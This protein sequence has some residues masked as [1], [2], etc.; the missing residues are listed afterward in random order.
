M[1][2]E[3]RFVGFMG[4]GIVWFGCVC[5]LAW[6][7]YNYATKIKEE[8]DKNESVNDCPSCGKFIRFVRW[9]F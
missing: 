9:L 3:I 2:D 4:I 1:Q 7:V 6:Q 8:G 5:M